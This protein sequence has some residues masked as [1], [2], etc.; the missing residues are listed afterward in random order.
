MMK[1][2]SI[3]F[4]IIAAIC[5]LAS[6][7]ILGFCQHRDID[8]DKLCDKC[9]ESYEDGKDVFDNH[10]CTSATRVENQV[11]PTCENDGSYDLVTYCTDCN[12]E[13]SRTTEV[14]L[15]LG[16]SYDNGKCIHCDKPDPNYT[17]DP[18]KNPIGLEFTSNGDGTCYVSGIGTCTDTDIVIPAISP[19][20][21]KVV[22]VGE[23]AF[24][25]DT[26]IT[27][28][29]ICEGV[30]T[31]G[32]GAFTACSSLASIDLP[33]SI[34]SVGNSSFGLCAIEI[35]TIP[36]GLT[37]IA[38]WAFAGCESLKAIIV[39]DSLTAI[40]WDC[41]GGCTSLDTVYYTGTPSQWSNIEIDTTFNGNV[42]I[43]SATVYSYSETQP[44]VAGNFW[45]YVDG[46]PTVW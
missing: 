17:P 42:E 11:D 13:I 31:I 35:V 14:V 9:G 29:V 27:S 30:T 32:N 25:A 7:D 33:D 40:Y 41:F 16:H 5:L 2:L 4:L 37:Y 45:H 3:I 12:K 24:E 22:A 46:V 8:D 26:T 1:K 20:G 34:T 44:T 38:P 15:S 10:V 21:E 39:S 18:P 43:L 28:V 36:V 19:S 23:F 6:C